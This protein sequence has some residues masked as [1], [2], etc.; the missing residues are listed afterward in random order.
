MSVK[1]F[2]RLAIGGS[3]D[4]LHTGHEATLR[5]AFAL[6]ERVLI[7]ITSDHFATSM[8]KKH[9]VEPYTH[10]VSELRA[11]LRHEEL[12]DR[13]EIIP[14]NSKFGVAD[15]EADLDAILVSS[16]RHPVALD[17]NNARE[18]AGLKRLEIVLNEKLLAED[19]GSFS[20][21]RIRSREIDR[22]GRILKRL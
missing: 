2:R 9:K 18:K 4:L 21:T 12:N 10:R 13:A 11:F 14:I 16:E 20:S 17:L 1:R 15:A 3:F 6:S 8:G 7:G 5:K 19:G 22:R